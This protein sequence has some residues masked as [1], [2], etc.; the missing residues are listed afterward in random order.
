MKSRVNKILLV[1]ILV[2]LLVLISRKFY[3]GLK[4]KFLSKEEVH[5]MMDDIYGKENFRVCTQTEKQQMTNAQI[6]FQ[7][8]DEKEGFKNINCDN[9]FDP[10][11]IQLD[12]AT[13]KEVCSNTLEGKLPC[14]NNEKRI[15]RIP[16]V[17]ECEE[18]FAEYSTI[19][20][21]FSI[22]SFLNQG[23]YDHLE[24]LDAVPP[25]RN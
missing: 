20:K 4:E 15:K 9:P 22:S 10:T 17:D 21:A 3:T 7:C 18:P 24:A 14:C 16:C 19:N 13:R 5:E 6:A 1:I 12:K 2:L 25:Y 23:N 8:D 11:F